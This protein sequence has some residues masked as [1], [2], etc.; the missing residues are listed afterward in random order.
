MKLAENREDWAWVARNMV[1]ILGGVSVNA[2]P[3]SMKICS[4][5]VRIP[6]GQWGKKGVPY[7]NRRVIWKDGERNENRRRCKE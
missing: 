5:V 6:E 4:F 1:K 2:G 3:R 7:K